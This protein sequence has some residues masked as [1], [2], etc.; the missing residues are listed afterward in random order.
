M[1]KPHIVD[2][3]TYEECQLIIDNYE[4]STLPG[5]TGMEEV[6]PPPTPL[7][8]FIYENEP[9]SKKDA[10]LFRFALWNGMRLVMGE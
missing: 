4:Y 2:L 8:E 1:I 5:I 3:P 7:Q 9:Y 10:E 6:P